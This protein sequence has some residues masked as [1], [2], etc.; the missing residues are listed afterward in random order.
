[1][2]AARHASSANKAGT[3]KRLQLRDSHARIPLAGARAS[4]SALVV[5]LHA[6]KTACTY[7]LLIPP[8]PHVGEDY[9][10]GAGGDLLEAGSRTCPFHIP[11]LLHH[12]VK[13][14]DKKSVQYP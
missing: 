4:M 7:L 3:V 5:L 12:R 6:R 14:G 8:Q 10:R 1:M 13:P 9:H 2:E 11:H